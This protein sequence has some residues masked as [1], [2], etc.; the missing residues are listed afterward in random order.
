MF[1]NPSLQEIVSDYFQFQENKPRITLAGTKFIQREAKLNFSFAETISFYQKQKL[2]TGQRI[3]KHWRDS[4]VLSPVGVT[5]P[6]GS[7]VYMLDP[8]EK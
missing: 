7:K 1:S 8:L 5:F 3:F 4:K 6:V 2:C